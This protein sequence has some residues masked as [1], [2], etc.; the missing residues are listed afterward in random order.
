MT[1]TH[2]A[3]LV[4]QPP[5]ANL[6]AHVQDCAQHL[7]VTLQPVDLDSFIADATTHLSHNGHVLA[8][9]ETGGLGVLLRCVH[10]HK[11]T[12]GLLPVHPKSKVCRLFGIPHAM[13]DAL[14]IAMQTEGAANLELLLC[15]GEVVTWMVSLGDAPFI[16]LRKM[17]YHQDLIWQH[18][19]TIPDSI[20]SLFRLQPKPITITTAKD[21]LIKTA[22]VGAVIIENDIESVVSHFAN[23]P[24][25][26]LDGKLYA[27]FIAPS[28]IMDYLSFVASALSLKPHLPRAISYV[29][30]ADLTLASDQEIHYYLDGQKRSAKQLAFHIMPHAVKVNVGTRFLKSH[31]AVEHDKDMMK[32]K[33]LP[34]GE[35][36]LK[37]LK[38][39]LPLF[40]TASEDDFKE[41]FLTLREYAHFSASFILFMVLSAMLATL[42]LFLDNAP[43]VIGAMLL[44][45]LMGPL[46]SLSMGML[47]ND[48]KLLKNAAQVFALGT[49]L[50]L[51]VAALATLMLPYEQATDE[52]RSRLQ[53][54]LLDLGVAIISGIAAAFAHARESIQK[55]LPGVAIAVALVP[56]ACVMGVGLGWLDWTI[57]SGAGLLFLTNL[58]G[59]V[60]AAM[61]TFLCLGFAPALRANRELGLSIILAVSVSI[62]LYHSL[63]NT[64][65]YQRME[66][67]IST[68][69]YQINGKTVEL[70]DVLVRPV[71]DK[72]KIM[73]QLHSPELIAASDIAALRDTISTQLEKPVQLDVSVRLVQ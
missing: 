2:N 21:T 10:E 33:T 15:N 42:G 28:S 49:G 36:R 5:Q 55:S 59:I 50:T 56:P 1:I 40:S 39:K 58:A 35:E 47:R 54:N 48:D 24:T 63:M 61:F 11:A 6:L 23:E 9:L 8:L 32:I 62:P 27:V 64:V 68:Q 70:S 45:P 71:D 20:R 26:T 44:A 29:K 52:I 14:P 25:S 22:L 65:V 60:L 37:R 66:K 73:A 69:A 30:T 31:K 46:V 17:A 41:V 13:E 19:T 34:Q 67:N 7:N 18:I 57:I 38:Q 43:V 72:I 51:L 4:Y 16:E 53:P 12:V 3:W